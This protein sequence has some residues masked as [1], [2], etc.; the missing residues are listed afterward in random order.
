MSESTVTLTLPTAVYDELQQ[1][2]RHHHR[3]VEEEATLTLLAA[4]GVGEA[5]PPDTAAAL[6]ALS[7]LDD[8]ALQRVS[9]S[10][11]TVEDGVLLGALVD[12]RRRHQLGSDEE[13]LLVE[14]IER[15]DRVMALRAEAIAL[16]AQ[17][18]VDVQER[19]AR[20]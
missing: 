9:H 15:H 1:R 13:Q 4:L 6:D 2:A 10:Q 11:P 20:A 12:K 19:V 7:L 16:L 5:L 8:E 3:H 17:R 18:G 14:L